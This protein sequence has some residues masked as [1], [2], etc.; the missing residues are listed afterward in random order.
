MIVSRGF[1]SPSSAPQLMASD[2]ICLHQPTT[3]DNAGFLCYQ[4]LRCYRKMD[5]TMYCGITDCGAQFITFML[6]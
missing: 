2:S 6:F 3:A 4:L 1:F 5:R